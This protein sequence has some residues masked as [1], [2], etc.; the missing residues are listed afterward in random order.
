MPPAADAILII[1]TLRHM[2]A[3]AERVF[4][5][6]PS[7]LIFAAIA[8]FAVFAFLLRRDTS[9]CYFAAAEF[10]LFFARHYAAMLF[11][12]FAC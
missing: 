8:D 4:L 5:P 9:L 10:S 1:A 3:A 7:L 2:P 12:L 6:P 11:S